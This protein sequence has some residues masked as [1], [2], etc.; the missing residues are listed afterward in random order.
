MEKNERIVKDK[1]YIIS[2]GKRQKLMV[3][4]QAVISKKHA[5]LTGKDK[6]NWQMERATQEGC[7][8]KR[9]TG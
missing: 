7:I 9:V 1:L 5:C 6:I 2:A 8:Q 3:A 4:K